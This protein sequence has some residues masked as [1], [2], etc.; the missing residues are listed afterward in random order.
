MTVDRPVL[1]GT[2]VPVPSG[3]GLP[4]YQEPESALS[5]CAD[6]QT[7]SSNFTNLESSGFFLTEGAISEAV[8][9]SQTLI[10]RP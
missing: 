5:H 3:T 8:D 9:D 7:G 1:S 4:C 10:V 2:T 6:C